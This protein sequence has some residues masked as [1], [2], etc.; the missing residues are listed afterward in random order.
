M[1]LALNIRWIATSVP[2]GTLTRTKR[3]LPTGGLETAKLDPNRLRFL[4]LRLDHWT[5][6]AF[7]RERGHLHS[8][9]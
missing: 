5:E 3:R 7:L 4:L 8:L 6:T 9:E 1:N 2:E